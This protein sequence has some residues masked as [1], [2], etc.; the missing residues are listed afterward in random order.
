MPRALLL[1]ALALA[2]IFAAPAAHA[3]WHEASTDH[4]VIYADDSEGDIRR[5]AENLERYHA[6]LALLTDRASE[7]PSP[8]NR[9]TIFVVGSGRDLREL[10]GSPRSTIAGFYVPRAGGSRAFVQDLRHTSGYPHFSTVILLHEY[11]HHFLLSSSRFPMPLWLSEGA[12]EFFASSSF[13]RDG[14]V[15]IGRAA[16]HRGRELHQSNPPSVRELLDPDTM[17][18]KRGPRKDG[19]YGRSWLLYHYLTF[20]EQRRGQF[21]AYQQALLGGLGSLEAGEAAFGD[22]DA[23]ESDLDDYLRGKVMTLVLSPEI[24]PSG[25]VSVRRLPKGEAKMM[26]VRI[27]SQRGVS[28]EQALELVEDARRI[29]EDYPD[30]PGVL[31]ALAEAEYDAGNDTAAIA[32]ADRA[33]AI[34][35]A[36]A[37]AYV[38]KGFALFRIAA[39][40]DEPEKPAAYAAAMAPFSALN[41]RENDHPQPLIHYY[42]SFAERGL[43]PPEHARAALERAALLAPFDQRLWLEVAVLQASEGKIGMAMAS[44]EPLAANPHG[45]NAAEIAARLIETLAEAPEGQ[46]IALG[47]RLVA[48]D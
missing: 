20:S 25:P 48:P 14:S 18:R 35:P 4:F 8:S 28:R 38:Q 15:I 27:A 17:R 34:D 9:L 32:A 43:Q 24:V 42:R 45:G 31:T 1:V 29:A 11:A 44:L 2:A 13:E 40:A 39:E 47:G 10:A 3:A 30:D 26:D 7:P 36:R 46:S 22:L 33:I 21:A 23:L 6:A 16:Q 37:N 41:A 5:Y 19:F 12:A